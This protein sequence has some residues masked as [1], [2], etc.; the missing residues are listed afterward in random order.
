MVKIGPAGTITASTPT[1]A[2]K[3]IAIDS[4]DLSLSSVDQ[5]ATVLARTPSYQC[6]QKEFTIKPYDCKLTILSGAFWV[7]SVNPLI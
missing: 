5:T 1:T 2:S 4:S 3:I 6:L 7:N